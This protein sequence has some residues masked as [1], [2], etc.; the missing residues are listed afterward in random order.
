MTT[1]VS[2]SLLKKSYQ[3]FKEL[4]TD[5]DLNEFCIGC[6][7]DYI[8][9]IVKYYYIRGGNNIEYVKHCPCV[10]CVV[11]PICKD[12]CFNFSRYVEKIKS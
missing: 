11:K 4:V 7:C 2:A 10:S 5:T 3:E 9:L 8:C 12:F 1:L 6:N